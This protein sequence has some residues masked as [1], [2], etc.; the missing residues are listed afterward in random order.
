MVNVLIKKFCSNDDNI[1]L[2]SIVD[3][4]KEVGVIIF[5]QRS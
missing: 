5:E 1:Y 2:I 3:V 4:F